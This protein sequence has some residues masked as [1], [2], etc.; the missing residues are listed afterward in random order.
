MCYTRVLK[1]ELASLSS[2][3][4]TNKQTNISYTNIASNK[5]APYVL[6]IIDI[7]LVKYKQIGARFICSVVNFVTLEPT[8]TGLGPR[9]T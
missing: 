6:G 8:V 3:T 2:E 7:Y 4:Q 9:F 1:R 5:Q